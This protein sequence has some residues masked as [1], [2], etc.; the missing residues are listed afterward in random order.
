MFSAAWAK[1]QPKWVLRGLLDRVLRADFIGDDVFKDHLFEQ[2][3]V[4]L[5]V[6]LE[7]HLFNHA[8]DLLGLFLST[9]SLKGHLDCLLTDVAFFKSVK[10]AEQLRQNP[11]ALKL[12]FSQGG[13]QELRVR[14][15]FVVAETKLLNEVL[16][17][18]CGE[19]H[20]VELLVDVADGF[21]HLRLTHGA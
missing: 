1:P 20:V 4:D 18:S 12:L 14:D 19:E 15:V 17:I 21:E 10:R 2:I 16:H 6:G 11:R 13:G 7:T 9:L 3:E 8:L 5:D